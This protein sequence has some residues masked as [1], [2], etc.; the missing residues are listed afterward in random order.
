MAFRPCVALHV[1][2]VLYRC[3][4]VSRVFLSLINAEKELNEYSDI[5]LSKSDYE[6]FKAYM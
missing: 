4:V 3:H 5:S 2:W 6:D 1:L